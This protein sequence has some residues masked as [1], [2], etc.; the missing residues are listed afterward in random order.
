MT[1]IVPSNKS[2]KTAEDRKSNFLR[3]QVTLSTARRRR[4]PMPEPEY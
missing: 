2:D 4:S 3:R 1:V